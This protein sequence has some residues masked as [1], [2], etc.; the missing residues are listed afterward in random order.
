MKYKREVKSFNIDGSTPS[1]GGK[2]YFDNVGKLTTTASSQ[3]I[4]RWLSAKDADGYAKV[5]INIV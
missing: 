3:Q 5:E 2:A 1:A 4:G